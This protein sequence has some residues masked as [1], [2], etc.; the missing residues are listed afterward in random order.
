MKNLEQELLR[1]LR[2]NWAQGVPGS[3][4]QALQ[5][6]QFET[7]ENRDVASIVLEDYRQR[8][9]RAQSRAAQSDR[10]ARTPRKDSVAE[11][12]PHFH[13]SS[14][15]KASLRLKR[16]YEPPGPGNC[17]F[18]FR[19]CRELGRGAFARV[20]L[21]EQ[22]DLAGR[23]VVLKVSSLEGREP[24]TVAQLQHTHIVPI[25]SLHE[26]TDAGLR[27]MCMPYF[28]GATLAQVLQALEAKTPRPRRGLEL[29]QA[30]ENVS[31]PG[32]DIPKAKQAAPHQEGPSCPPTPNATKT[33]SSILGGLD[34]V[35]AVAWVGA[36]LAEG[37]QHA[38][39]RGVLHR[40]VKPQNILLGSD[41]QPLLLDF[42]LAHDD[43]C[44]HAEN[45]LGGTL[46]YMAPE[47]HRAVSARDPALARNVDE[48]ADLY[49]LGMVIFEM[50]AGRKPFACSISTVPLPIL[51][52]SMALERGRA[53][54]SVRKV[55][56]DV[57]W[58]MESILRRCLAPAPGERYRHAEELAE[59]LQ[60]FVADEPLRHAP[61]LSIVERG[62]KW[63][64]RHPP[65][66]S[67]GV[68]CAA[69]S[70]LLGISGLALA[71]AKL[72][73]GSCRD[74]IYSGR[75]PIAIG[76]ETSWAWPFL[77]TRHGSNSACKNG[78]VQTTMAPAGADAQGRVTENGSG[79]A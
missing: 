68:I 27:A 22:I 61:E 60:R 32:L 16:K 30:L 69:A 15:F 73:A 11:L 77:K 75:V 71:A 28:G 53:A 14:T 67:A 55:R 26:D 76:W 19:L 45:S 49:S 29:L 25:F 40:N 13:Q 54:P 41:A 10:A 47:H 58:G 74:L 51:L 33:P 79:R 5:R 65:L 20:F 62:R 43:R 70:L 38:H 8:L 44:T 34:Y 1:E 46:A 64:R 2:L 36:R 50:L 48:R 24:Q 4:E 72:L 42:N 3:Q 18:G 9:Q 37:L 35:K 12:L 66:S 63:V 78:K 59:D 23:P 56:D 7:G 17:L 39:Q 21:A 57:P 52:E 6:I 31:A